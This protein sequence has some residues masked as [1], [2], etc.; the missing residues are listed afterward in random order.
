MADFTEICNKVEATEVVKLVREV[1]SLFDLLSENHKVYKVRCFW[2]YTQNS[3]MNS[4]LAG[5]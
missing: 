2:I 1:F 5:V 3:F 4:L